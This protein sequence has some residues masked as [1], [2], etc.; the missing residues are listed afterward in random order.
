MVVIL[1]ALGM[2]KEIMIEGSV[3]HAST[4]PTDHGIVGGLP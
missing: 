1:L 4:L 3:A 2:Y